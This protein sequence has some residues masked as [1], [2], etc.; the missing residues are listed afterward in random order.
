[1]KRY[2]LI[3]EY[4]GSPTLHTEIKSQQHPD[5]INSLLWGDG[6]VLYL[7]LDTYDIVNNP[8]YWREVSEKEY[9]I[10][11]FYALNIGG[12]GNIPDDNYIWLPTE[13]RSKNK[14]SRLGYITSP[15]T[16]QE[17]LIHKNYAIHSVKRLSDGEIFT[18]GDKV[19]STTWGSDGFYILDKLVIKD[20]VLNLVIN[21]NNFDCFYTNLENFIKPSKQKLFTTE[22][23][24]D[25]FENDGFFIISLPKLS[26]FH[27]TKASKN[28]I[29]SNKNQLVYANK[30]VAEDYIL[31]N[32]PCL[33]FNDVVDYLV[34]YGL[35]LS[36]ESAPKITKELMKNSSL[37]K[38]VEKK[39][40]G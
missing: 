40:N 34:K 20:N 17:L 9:E 12:K 32:K 35:K 8:E 31:H 5:Y 22:D 21:E 19:K 10:L 1:M 26:I 36:S 38:I 13:S 33:S 28:S 7:G 11:S 29:G 14:W 25:I 18:I 24:V 3:K 15:Y 6:K 39:I 4:P 16:T 2:K 37:K 27:A 23:G 30:E